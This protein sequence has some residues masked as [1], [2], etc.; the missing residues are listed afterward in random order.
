MADKP[1]FFD[2]LN[3]MR[4]LV[5]DAD[6]PKKALNRMKNLLCDP[7]VNREF[8]KL[9]EGD[10]K[11]ISALIDNDYFSDPPEL[12][13]TSGGR[14][15]YQYWPQSG[16]LVSVA[17]QAPQQ[18]SE[19][20]KSIHTKNWFVVQDNFNA[21]AA[22]PVEYVP[23]IIQFVSEQLKKL[24]MGYLLDGI[25][26]FTGRLIKE[27]QLDVA[28]ILVESAFGI[29]REHASEL[30]LPNRD[31]SYFKSLRNDVIPS[32]GPVEGERLVHAMLGWLRNV[33]DSKEGSRIGGDD[34]SYLWRPAMEDHKQNRD[35]DFAAKLV[36]CLRVACEL[37]VRETAITLEAILE[38]LN[39]AESLIERR[40]RLHL[41]NE[42]ADSNQELARQ[43]M[44]DITNFRD[45]G[46]KHEYARLLE[47]R[48]NLL[49]TEEQ[50]EWLTWIDA[51]PESSE[52]D[53]VAGGGT[54]QERKEY[55]QFL[56]L[57]WIENY[58]SGE[59]KQL[60]D[61]LFEVNGR[62]ELADLNV[63]M[64][65][66]QVGQTSGYTVVE[67]QN[68]GLEQ[69]IKTVINWRPD[70]DGR[71]V[72][73][74]SIRGLTQVFSEY[75]STDPVTFSSQASLLISSPACYVQAYLE[76]IVTGLREKNAIDLT[77]VLDL[78]D[79]VVNQT[80]E[81]NTSS[82]TESEPL[83]DSNWQWC[84]DAVSDLLCEACEARNDENHPQYELSIRETIWDVIKQL[85]FVPE[86][87]Y[88]ENKEATN[89]PRIADWPLLSLNSALG[90]AMNTVFAYAN[91]VVDHKVPDRSEKPALQGG[92]EEMPEVRELLEIQLQRPDSHFTERAVYGKK[93]G[94]LYYLDAGWLQN[95]SNKIFNLQAYDEKPSQAYGWAAWNSFLFY[96]KP[97]S[98]FYKML[99]EQYS[100]AVAQATTL[101]QPQD[102]SEKPFARL[103]QHLVV[104]YG[105]GVL[106]ETPEEAI[107]SDDGVIRRLVTE[108]HPSIR[109]Q[110]IEFIGQMMNGTTEK[111]P[112]NVELRF[113]H[114]WEMYWRVVG[115]K[116]AVDDQTSGAFGRWFS[117]GVF[118][119]QWSLDQLEMFVR[120]V[121]KPEPDHMILERLVEVANVNPEQCARIVGCM[122]DG[123][124]EHWRVSSWES[125]A[126]AVLLTAL[127]AGGEAKSE[128]L[129]VIDRLGRAGY[130]NFE[131]LWVQ[132]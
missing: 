83:I 58:I 74:P 104:L 90:K 71:R 27:G 33:V 128:A 84:R 25:G 69:A 110:A 82:A 49:N 97:H 120:V 4:T 66:V 79:W 72:G 96:N 130:L 129:Q 124:D 65:D 24:D 22:M 29:E 88:I 3:R 131:E 61:R 98:V 119:T 26:K 77:S 2:E 11:W 42:F 57:C 109:S 43:T 106:G 105:H 39:T 44:M 117:S 121:P 8:F 64:S 78:C 103:G 80:L 9:I 87:L 55:W 50:H 122:V 38:L 40:L 116:D 91:W 10:S 75:I 118:D 56:R 63:Y 73:E 54:D 5:Q 17:A 100:Y 60:Y 6:Q 111:L 102:S 20:I 53:D 59:W 89:D 36:G 31:H 76:G 67:L 126:K 81:E 85:L 32:I 93:L 92:F 125:E 48:F 62:P 101:E 41:I 114:L 14:L 113:Q 99:S 28:M 112:K 127:A 86:Q 47:K 68:R 12:Q 46:C 7:I 15:L 23:I 108:T 35:Y 16:Y 37:C 1:S 107:D 45:Y 70:H 19:I 34:L 30:Q 52:D 51:G 132:L 94:L 123:D 95:Q 115:E 13:T 21:M 18:V